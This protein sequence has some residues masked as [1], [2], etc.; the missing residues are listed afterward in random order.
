MTP[1][2][3]P[4]PLLSAAAAGDARQVGHKFARQAELRRTDFPVPDFFCLPAA[5]FDAVLAGLPARPAPPGGTGTGQEGRRDWERWAAARRTEIAAASVPG[6]GAAQLLAAFDDLI[7]PRGTAAVRACAVAGDDDDGEDSAADPFAGLSDSFLYVDRDDLLRR[8]VDCWA[9]AFTLRA[10]RYRL[11]QGLDPA[12]TRIAVGVQRMVPAARSFVAFSRDPVDGRAHCVVAAAYGVG[13]G[14]VQEQADLDHFTVERSG[15]VAART[16]VKARMVDRNPSGRGTAVRAVPPE[17]AQVPVLTDAEAAAVAALAVRIEAHYG[18]AQDVEGALTAEG[19]LFLVQARPAA[20][21]G[22]RARSEPDS[23]SGP[24]ASTGAQPPGSQPPG[25][26]PP[27]SRPPGPASPGGQGPPA[28]GTGREAVTEPA[29]GPVVGGAMVAYANSNATES[30]PGVC[31]TLT[32]SVAAHLAELVLHDYYR[33][34]GVPV[35]QLRRHRYELRRL[36]AHLDGRIYYRMDSWYRLHALV[37]DFD[38][39][40]GTWEPAIG[41]SGGARPGPDG[42]AGLGP[43]RL[44]LSRLRARLARLRGRTSVLRHRVRLARLAL[45]LPPRLLRTRR[46]IAGLL[47]WWDRRFEQ[48]LDAGRQE[49]AEIV[50]EYQRLWSQAGE[51]WGLPSVSNFQGLVATRLLGS[52]TRRWAADADGGALSGMLCGGTES[53]SAAALRSTMELAERVRDRP[54]L[55][56]ALAGADD[57]ATWA[58]L[59]AGSHGADLATAALQH[60]RRYGDRGPQDL[61]LEAGTV[62]TAPWTLLPLLRAYAE[63]PSLSV[64]DSRRRERR[65]RAEAEAEL[66]AHCPAAGRR[67]VLRALYAVV[68]ECARLREDVRFARSQLIG[69]SRDMLLAL[70]ADLAAAGLLADG[71]DVLD[72][73]VDEVLGAYQGTSAGAELRGLAALRQA[74]REAWSGLPD[75][76]TQL[77]LPATVPLDRALRAADTGTR[78]AGSTREAAGPGGDGPVRLV[79][80]GSS[81]G[82]VRARARVLLEPTVDPR[83]CRDR[84]LVA[85]ET[86]PGWLFLMVAAR[87]MVVQNGSPLSHTAITGRVLGIPTVVAVPGVLAAVRDGD[88]IEIDG[89]TGT[90]TPA[91]APAPAP[92]PD[93]VGVDS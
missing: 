29:P 14:V 66:R 30:Y 23:P 62:R 8:V 37:P 26:R 69:L 7:G 68:R 76:P 33:R 48:A 90:V 75:L 73:T 24:P 6:G 86:D 52:L 78:A 12:A 72:L 40:R 55:C 53:R 81:P 91:P 38:L 88:W 42:I 67:L 43:T 80:I 39:L 57:R 9:S 41:L 85:R 64:A 18:T 21:P 35:E 58:A 15:A 16:V 4:W 92:A 50:E 46:R 32:Y 51:L 82:R 87:G 63:Q 27:G 83:E 84:I 56:D 5:A 93:A 89:S 19:Q 25:S 20:V 45:L 3:A 49:P 44:G 10:V 65:V 59:I 22:L 70:G 31:C 54:R 79:G 17:L 13:E 28:P 36:L 74:R 61:K 2:P 71:R 34:M 60:V 77:R 11:L 1:V 47:R